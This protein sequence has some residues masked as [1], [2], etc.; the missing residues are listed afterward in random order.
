MVCWFVSNY[1]RAMQNIKDQRL[2]Q[3]ILSRI[4]IFTE[5][6]CIDTSKKLFQGVPILAIH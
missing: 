4:N 3:A 6:F 1:D 2:I 5:A